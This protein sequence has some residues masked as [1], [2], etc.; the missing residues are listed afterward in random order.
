MEIELLKQL[1]LALA[2]GLLVG[3]E[4]ETKLQKS[5]IREFGGIRTYGIIGLLGALSFI[6]GQSSVIYPAIIGIGFMTMLVMSYWVDSQKLKNIGTTSEMGAIAVY[7]IG[8]L[9]GMGS[10]LLAISLGL[11]TTAILH[12][13]HSLHQLARQLNNQEIIASLKFILIAF[14]ILPILPNQNLGPFGFFNP[15]TTWLMVVLISGISY[16]S[17]IAIKI[18]GSNRGI[19]ITGFLAGFISSTALTLSFSDQSKKNPKVINPYAVA[20]I[21][22]SSAMFFRVLVEVTV[23]NNNLL[24]SLLVPMATMGITG[25]IGAVLLWIRSPKTPTAIN[26][27]FQQLDSPFELKPALQFGLL[28]VAISL[29]AKLADHWFGQQ[30]IYV[31]SIISG[32]ADV[33]AITV[34]MANLAKDNNITSAVATLAITIA[35]IT[36]TIVKVSIFYAL[37]HKK[38]AFRIATVMGLV[39]VV[40]ISSLTLL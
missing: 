13:K 31:T 15:Y 34:T 35:T 20:I 8:I 7:A 3:I 19:G 2:L 37:G 11:A 1:G 36:N 23:I 21:I 33:D 17:Y 27:E 4:R 24:N 16:L 30:G 29:I 26:N 10:Y 32:I 39:L 38:V 22:A 6:L 9:A 28:F 18:L 40:G 5:Q 25:L 12:F 14:V